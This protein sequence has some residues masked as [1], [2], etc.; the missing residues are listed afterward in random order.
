MRSLSVFANADAGVVEQLAEIATLVSAPQGTVLFGEGEQHDRLYFVGSGTITL[1]M[2]TEQCRK[3][4]VLTVVQGDL[5]A[6]S[7]ILGDAPMTAS[8]L[9]TADATLIAFRAEQLD[10]LCR[11]SYEVGYLV[12]LGVV[13][14]ISRRLLATRLQ[15]LDVFHR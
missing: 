15:L 8:A 12:M 10:N 14:L 6:W 3:Q 13:K 11:R 7:A 9:V 4:A 5:P 2:V 1:E